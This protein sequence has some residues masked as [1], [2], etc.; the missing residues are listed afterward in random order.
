M[1][2]GIKETYFNLVFISFLAR[3]LGWSRWG[4]NHLSWLDPYIKAL[5]KR[6]SN[7]CYQTIFFPDFPLPGHIIN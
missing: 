1:C 3:L 7:G 6:R 2:G 5:A 4:S